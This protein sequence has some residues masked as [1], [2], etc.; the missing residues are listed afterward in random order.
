MARRQIAESRVLLTGA[1]S[2]IGRHLALE[3]AQ[4]GAKVLA[5][6]RREEKLQSLAAE[7][8][9]MAGAVEPFCGDVTQAAT[10]AGALERIEQLWG[11]LDLLIN[12]AGVSA[13]GRFETA[14][15]RR[16][17]QIMEVNFFAP[18]ELT[19]LALPL[20]Q[21]GRRPMI[22]NI[23]SI[24]GHRGLPHNSEYCASKFAL[25]GF[26]QSLRSEVARLGIEVLLVSPGTTDTEFSDHLLEDA[27]RPWKQPR[28]VAPERVAQAT[29]RAIIRGRHELI[30]SRSGRLLVGLNRFCPRL[31]D[32]IL[33]RYG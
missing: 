16:L 31:L 15:P 28:G 25:T 18:V 1:S 17:Q 24:L 14:Q 19:R 12:N 22:V 4:R 29:T 2:G 5:M 7:A 21:Q 26:T 30:P 8:Q 32:W 13:H 27:G 9:N 3:L 23:G 10:R 6:A 11:G 33:Q 20:L